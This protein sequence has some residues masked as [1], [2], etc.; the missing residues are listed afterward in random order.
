MKITL[1]QDTRTID[2]MVSEDQIPDDL[3]GVLPAPTTT[4]AEGCLAWSIRFGDVRRSSNSTDGATDELLG[5]VG[6]IVG[7]IASGDRA[8]SVEARSVIRGTLI[9]NFNNSLLEE[10][11]S[12]GTSRILRA[13]SGLFPVSSASLDTLPRLQE[14]FSA[15]LATVRGTSNSESSIDRTLPAFFVEQNSDQLVLL[16]ANPFG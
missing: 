11:S 10:E 5:T 12:T 15:E 1:N 9:L 4:T 2:I 16:F 7:S 3:L 8:S 14:E 6:A 13:Y